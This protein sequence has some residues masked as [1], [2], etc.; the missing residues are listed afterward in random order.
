M[1]HNL[2]LRLSHQFPYYA[3]IYL[4]SNTDQFSV[5]NV[6]L[7]RQLI[8]WLTVLSQNSYWIL[9]NSI[10]SN[11]SKVI[12]WGCIQRPVLLLSCIHMPVSAVTDWCWSTQPYVRYQIKIN[13]LMH[14]SFKAIIQPQWFRSYGI[15]NAAAN[16]ISYK[17]RR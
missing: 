2:L 10:S 8:W 15:V 1:F 11:L 3:K 7:T 16:W 9:V 17:Q 14:R 13:S 6:T 5:A 4:R 12:T